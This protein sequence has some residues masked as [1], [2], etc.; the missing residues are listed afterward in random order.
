MIDTYHLMSGLRIVEQ[1][2]LSIQGAVAGYLMCGDC[3][4]RAEAAGLLSRLSI[5][6]T[7]DA[8]QRRSRVSLFPVLGVMPA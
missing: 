2:R 4:V 7:A 3:D 1:A 5:F 8:L 6:R